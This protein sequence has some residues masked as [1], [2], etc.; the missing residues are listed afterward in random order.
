M[1]KT[2]SW[3]ETVQGIYDQVEREEQAEM[4]GSESETLSEATE[5]TVLCPE[6]GCDVPLPQAE[7]VEQEPTED[8]SEASGP[9]AGQEGAGS[10]PPAGPTVVV[11]DS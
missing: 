3:N 9:P 2:K 6:C 7:N 8:A 1:S 10:A 4:G 5:S 11:I